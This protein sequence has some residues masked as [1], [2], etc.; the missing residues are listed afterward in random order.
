LNTGLSGLNL[1]GTILDNGLGPYTTLE[2]MM[3][4]QSPDLLDQS[5]KLLTFIGGL[6]GFIVAYRRYSQTQR[7]KILEFVASEIKE[8]DKNPDV[9]KAKK[10]LDWWEYL[11]EL[12]PGKEDKAKRRVLV[13]DELVA[14]ALRTECF[15]QNFTEEEVEIRNIFDAFFDY[16]DRFN[17]YIESGLVRYEQFHPYLGYWL[18]IIVGEREDDHR[19]VWRCA[20]RRFIEIYHPAGTGQLIRR[21][22]R[23]AQNNGP[24]VLDMQVNSTIETSIAKSGE[25]GESME[26]LT[27]TTRPESRQPN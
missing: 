13:K 10:M 7:W 5:V 16:L 18:A 4:S 27:G 8:F 24:T 21:Y 17:N 14:G 12:F 3:S 25:S 20:L 23:Y 19:T 11:V 1:C 15:D 6:V 26:R 9:Q 22:L 2:A